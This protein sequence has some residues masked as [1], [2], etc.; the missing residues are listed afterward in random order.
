MPRIAYPGFCGPSYVAQSS[1]TDCEDCINFLVESNKA[2]HA[3][4]PFSLLPTPGVSLL[5]LGP[6][7]GSRG[8]LAING[9]A[10]I[11][12]GPSVYS[13]NHDFSWTFIGTVAVNANPATV[14]YN[15]V[16]GQW[17][18][19]SGSNGYLWVPGT[20]TFSQVA[21]MTGNADMGGYLDGFFLALNRSTGQ[22]FVSKAGDGS[23]WDLTQFWQRSAFPDPYTAFIVT[24]AGQIV[25]FGDQNGEIWGDFGTSPIPF[26]LI[27]GAK[28]PQGIHAQYSAR[29]VGATTMW[30]AQNAEGQRTVQQLRGYTPYQV[31]TPPLEWA[32]RQYANAKDAEILSYDLEGHLHAVLNCPS[33]GRSW[34]YDLTEQMWHRRGTWNAPIADFDVWH[35]QTHL[36]FNGKHLVTDRFTNGLYELSTDLLLDFAGGPLRRVRIPPALPT[37]R[38]MVYRSRLEIYGEMGLA[39]LSGQG[40]LPAVMLRS[41]KNGGKTWGPQRVRNFGVTGDY[42]HSCMFGTLPAARMPADEISMSDPAPW[43]I[44]DAFITL[45]QGLPN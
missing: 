12:Y 38:E 40:A 42:R 16:Q 10:L 27:G 31:S 37:K 8:G 22:M 29:N 13:I 34:G 9:Q 5:S 33:A 35:A 4:S 30:L 43:R 1:L 21:N 26:G 14:S 32:L 6:S 36:M 28:F 20:S 15:G 3:Q 39:S 17:W 23:T 44:T 7:V 19:T 11:V 18:I 41:S 2:P 25:L 24:P 45:D